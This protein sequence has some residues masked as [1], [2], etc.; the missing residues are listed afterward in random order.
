MDIGSIL[1]AGAGGGIFGI[2][3]QLANRGLAIY[4]LAERRKDTMLANQQEE[5]R[6]GH[7]ARL[8]EMQA[9]AR[10]EET[11]QEIALADTAGAWESFTASQHAEASIGKSYPWV[12][13][14]R[15][16]TR[17]ALTLEAQVLLAIVYFTMHGDRA[18]L[19]ATIVETVTFCASAS[20]LWWFGERAERKTR[21]R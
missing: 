15:A 20:L 2:V 18:D 9:K 17:P 16:L 11:E 10:A 21:G 1:T 7:E 5:K 4:E 14:V 6:W 19:Q 12:D 13:A 8:L 3:G